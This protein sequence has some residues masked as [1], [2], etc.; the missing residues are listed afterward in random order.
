MVNILSSAVAILSAAVAVQSAALPDLISLNEVNKRSPNANPLVPVS[1]GAIIGRRH[2]IYDGV[3]LARTADPA[4]DPAASELH[5][6]YASRI[7]FLNCNPFGQTICG[8][9]FYHDVSYDT[10]TCIPTPVPNPTNFLVMEE[11]T[12]AY[13]TIYTTADC[14]GAGFTIAGCRTWGCNSFSAYG[15][16]SVMARVGCSP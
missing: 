8:T 12:N 1:S 3:K 6:R 10:A 11:M 16:K 5:K 9:C 15:T 7:R 4:L 14:S 13:A 2:Y